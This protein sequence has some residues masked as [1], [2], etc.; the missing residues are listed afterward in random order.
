MKI[1]QE[2]PVYNNN[3]EMKNKCK[4]NELN[5]N[6]KREKFHH[7][8]VSF[9][10]NVTSETTT[11]PKAKKEESTLACLSST[12][13]IKLFVLFCLYFLLLFIISFIAFGVQFGSQ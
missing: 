8:I 13:T 12:R 10:I 9:S 6:Q 5:K 3:N 11:T 2:Q 7:V 4:N 1:K